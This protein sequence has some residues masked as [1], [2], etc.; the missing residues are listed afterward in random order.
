MWGTDRRLDGGTD[1][2]T[3][4]MSE[5]WMT[6]QSEI[7]S[8]RRT[9]GEDRGKDMTHRNTPAGQGS[10]DQRRGQQKHTA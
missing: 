5:C 4:G 7:V 10:G 3:A 9:M 8:R 1:T 2:R 6:N